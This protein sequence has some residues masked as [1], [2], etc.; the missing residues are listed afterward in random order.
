MKLRRGPFHPSAFC[1]H[2]LHR[3]G[4]GNPTFDTAQA[5]AVMLAK[6]GIASDRANI[7]LTAFR[8]INKL[9]H[10][11]FPIAWCVLG[12]K[13]LYRR[14]RA[15][16]CFGGSNQNGRSSHFSACISHFIIYNHL[17]TN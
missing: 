10:P 9:P 3:D 2:T 16:F 1:L 11:H 6:H 7:K 12:A 5:I 17:H 14:F 8:D 4:Q 13:S 15:F